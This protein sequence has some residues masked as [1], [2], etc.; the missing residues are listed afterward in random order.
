M[1]GRG[2]VWDIQ[3]P[4]TWG[5]QQEGTTGGSW[6]GENGSGLGEEGKWHVVK[7]GD[8]CLPHPL[9]RTNTVLVKV[10]AFGGARPQARPHCFSLSFPVVIISDDLGKTVLL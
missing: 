7:L 4:M 10:T 5:S 8:A 3:D 9:F 2:V 6:K 1:G